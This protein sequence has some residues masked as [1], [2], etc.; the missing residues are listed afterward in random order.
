MRNNW[1]TYAY[2]APDRGVAE[3]ITAI[4]S[5]LCKALSLEPVDTPHLRWVKA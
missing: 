1:A 5:E 4:Q 2:A 3:K